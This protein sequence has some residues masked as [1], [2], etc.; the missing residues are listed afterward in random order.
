MENYFKFYG[1]REKQT[2]FKYSFHLQTDVDCTVSLVSSFTRHYFTTGNIELG[3]IP[4]FTLIDF[5]FTYYPHHQVF[6]S[7]LVAYLHD[8]KVNK[9][10]F[11]IEATCFVSRW[12]KR[13]LETPWEIHDACAI[14]V[15]SQIDLHTKVYSLQSVLSEV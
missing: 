6:R 10:K 8:D 14:N 3:F 15:I 11:F 1:K 4:I 7:S 9:Y 2:I 13:N 5:I 12:N